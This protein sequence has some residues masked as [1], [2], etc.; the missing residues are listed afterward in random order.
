MSSNIL[1]SDIYDRI[2]S[3]YIT[4]TNAAVI[5]TIPIFNTSFCLQYTIIM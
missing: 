1:L 4:K 3:P 5:S 2:E